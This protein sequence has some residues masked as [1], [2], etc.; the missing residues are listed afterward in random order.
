MA[1]PYQTIR[2][3]LEDEERNGHVIRF[4]QPIK[5]GDYD[6]LVDIDFRRY[7][8][9]P[10]PRN[11]MQGV[12]PAT[13]VRALCRYLHT[14]PGNP[15]GI[16]EN[17]VCNRPDIPVVV[18][19]WPSID[20]IWPDM[21]L[22]DKAAFVEKMAEFKTKRI[23]PTVVDKSEALCK[24]VIIP[25]DEVDLRTSIPRIWVEFNKLCFTACNGTIIAYD[26]ETGTHGLT[27][28]RLAVFD[29]DN[30]DPNQPFSEEKQKR[31]GFA[32]MAR[33]GRPG[34]GNTGRYYFDN[35][36]DQ[37]KSWPAAFVY[38]LT[39]DYHVVGG[40]KR[41]RWPEMGDEY[42]ILGGM[43]GE[44]VD[45]VESETIP[46]M[47]VPAHAEWV[48]EGEFVNEDYRTPPCSEDLFAGFI[49]GEAL[50]PV[51]KVNCI[52]HRTNPLWT[53]ATFSSL[54]SQ[55]HAGV[56]QGLYKIC[57]QS[58]AIYNLRQAGYRIK[59]VAT[60]AMWAVVVQLEVDGR[61][62]PTPEYGLEIG[63]LV[64]AKYT[65]VVGPDINPYDAE[66]VLWAVGMR[67][68][69][70]LWY[71]YPPPPPGVPEIPRY[72]IFNE[73]TTDMGYTVIDATI[74]APGGFHTFPP[75]TEPP[76]WERDAIE[77][78]QAKLSGVLEALAR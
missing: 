21:G 52:T 5:C 55:D 2:D 59:D 14:L 28:T 45:V 38:G 47:M 22:P 6:N 41:V 44:A 4:K 17:P 74:Q 48:I 31:Y 76:V 35:F 11:E 66:D 69:R 8:A 23:P 63:K 20:G 7:N 24:Q 54:S 50:W 67:A 25:E 1:Y 10:D 40:L 75:R 33:P 16:I 9:A 78:I 65:I 29:W 56:H 15:I 42:E 27:K 57:T 37:G 68:P 70:N 72:G 3:W 19:L 61:D 51:F 32:T 77:R 71:D 58:D 18:N 26:P 39:A 49:W 34:Q 73:V 43:R 53:G 13:D 64:G 36:R 60:L 62:K 30:G 46:G 12:H